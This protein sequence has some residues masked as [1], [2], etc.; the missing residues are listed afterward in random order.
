MMPILLKDI[1]EEDRPRE[2]LLAYGAKSLSNEELLS[3]I[4]RTGSRGESVSSIS[5]EVLKELKSISDLKDASINSLKKIKGL[6]TAKATTLLASIE[7]GKRIFSENNIKERTK[8]NN[9]VDAYRF[10]A[11]YISDSKQENFMAIYLN[12]QKRYL[13]HKI[14]FKGT[15]DSSLVHPREVFKIALLESAKAII[16]MHNHPS[17]NVHPSKAD[18]EVTKVLIEAGE[19]LGIK[20]LDHLVVS[21]EGYYSFLEEGMLVYE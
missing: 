13:T 14:I 10:F 18:D 19:I 6:K 4:F 20:V 8:I 2:R 15:L 3:I 21:R 17:G 9:S 12:S 11:K 16:V 7:L 5:R 1:P